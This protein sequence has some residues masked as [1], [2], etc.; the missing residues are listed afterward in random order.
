MST[1]LEALRASV[2]RFA[3]LVTPLGERVT[4][5]AFP[6]EWTIADVASHL[7][8]SA[9]IFQRRLDA[10]LAG[11]DV[12]D[13][14]APRVWAEWDAKSPAAKVHDALVVDAAFTTRLETATPDERSRVSM[15]MGPLTWD[16]DQVVGGRLNEHL[17]HEWDVAVALDPDA[18]LA[19]DG[20]AHMIDHVELI[21]RWTARPAG[22]PRQVTIRT[23]GP[24]RAF[25]VTV[26]AD[27]V[28]FATTP[29]E[30]APTLTMPAEAL[31]RLVY[32]RLDADHT[33]ASVVGDA[34]ALDQL[35]LVF[36]GL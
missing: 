6:T 13:D 31:I 36:R 33:S 35:R 30:S 5:H 14:L 17:V 32:G 21:A 11:G 18:T 19:A 3:A 2:G 28:D 7:G 25:A 29:A 16:W 9:V 12:T 27:G 1:P 10:G 4:L 23:T 20:V 15:S 26:R 34:A 22:E 24:D 8:S